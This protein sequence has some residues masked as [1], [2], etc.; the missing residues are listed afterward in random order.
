MAVEINIP[1]QNKTQTSAEWATD[2]TVYS[3]MLLFISDSTYLFTNQQKFKKANGINTFAELDFMPIDKYYVNSFKTR[4]DAHG[5]QSE[6]LECLDT[7]LESL[8]IV[9]SPIRKYVEAI[10]IDDANAILDLAALLYIV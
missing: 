7:Q 2:T 8:G 5:G 3:D 10:I 9:D 4:V 6:A 1:S